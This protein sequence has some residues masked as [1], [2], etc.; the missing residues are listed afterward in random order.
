MKTK[1]F[2]ARMVHFAIDIALMFPAWALARWIYLSDNS[3]SIP[4]LHWPTL[5]ALFICF[6]IAFFAGKVYAV[7]WTH[8][9]VKDTYRL[10]ASCAAGSVLF[11]IASLACLP[12]L[13]IALAVLSALWYSLFALFSRMISRDFLPRFKQSTRQSGFFTIGEPPKERNILIVGAGEAGRLV[14]SEYHRKG[15]DSHIAGFVDDDPAKVGMIINGKKVFAPTEK[16]PRVIEEEGVNEIILAFPSAPK[17][18]V[19]RVVQIIRRVSP[20]MPVKI[21]PSHTRL[22]EN[23]LSPDIREIGIADLLDREETRLDTASIESMLA[24][25]RVLITG[26]GGSIG[27]ELS[28]QLLKFPIASLVAVG[29]GE[30]SIYQLARTLFEYEEYLEEKRDISF[31]IADARDRQMMAKLLRNSAPDIIF[32]AAAHKHVPLCE[33]NE[34]EAIMNNICGTR[35]L[36]EEALHFPIE[37]FVLVSTDKAVRPTSIM[38]A[39]K[40]AAELITWHYAE[41]GMNA[42]IVRFGNVIGSR[43]S[44]IPL[45]R[46][47]IERGGPVT[48][49]HPDITRFFM[50]IPEAALLV[51]NAAAYAKG[52]EIF[53]LDM[54]KQYRVMEIAENLIRLYGLE[55]HRDIEIRITGLRPGEKLYEELIY[56]GT[57]DPTE[58]PKILTLAH[59]G[60]PQCAAAVEKFFSEMDTLHTKSAIE[61]RM[62]LQQLVPEYSFNEE[63]FAKRSNRRLVT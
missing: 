54:G 34:A 25:K 52:G 5:L 7:L 38:G 60:P 27:S 29:K 22:F 44:V 33:F 32:H 4:L 51:L 48:V 11:I 14:L 57:L 19:T 1:N 15:I 35:N 23:P 45:F 30:H 39:T 41:K 28:K 47:Q 50:S 18:E 49:T 61:I 3:L 6:F 17:Q 10:I 62:M 59:D 26:A 16:L 8:S 31:H 13:P 58:N 20:A 46:E 42:S 9:F 53:V 36:L 37:R 40:R 21:L 55:P 2:P 63:E 12:A 24:G 43:G 56:Q